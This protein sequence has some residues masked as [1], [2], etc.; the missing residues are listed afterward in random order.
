MREVT[1]F[2]LAGGAIMLAVPA[3]ILLPD[4][5][6]PAADHLDPPSRTDPSP[7][8]TPDKAA[9]IADVYAWHTATSLIVAVTFA[10][11]QSKTAPA[12]YDRDVLYTI[13][14]STALPRSTPEFVITARFGADP[15]APNSKFGVQ[16]AGLPGVTGTIEGPV[17]TNLTKDGVTV[18]AGLVDDPFFFDLQGFRSTLATGNLAITNTRD[19]FAGQN[20]S[21]IIIEIPRDRLGSN[22]LDIWSTT[23]RFGGNI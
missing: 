13:N 14:I 11:P 22:A 17:E 15:T 4:A 19:F 18:R 23:A 12:V 5:K 3:A 6:A 20:D 10:G 21:A 2:L 9:D 16:F 1:K 8:P 7:D